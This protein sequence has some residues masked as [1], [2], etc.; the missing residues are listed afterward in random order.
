MK[1]KILLLFSCLL[2]SVGVFASVQKRDLD[3]SFTAWDDKNITYTPET[4]TFAFSA[5]WAGGSII[6]WESF[7]HE[8]Y[9]QLYVKFAS[10]PQGKIHITVTY[11]DNTNENPHKTTVKFK[12]NYCIVELNETNII[13]ISIQNDSEVASHS[14]ALEELCLRGE[15]GKADT[16]GNLLNENKDLGNWSF[17][18]RY[19]FDAADFANAQEGSR[20]KIDYTLSSEATGLG[21]YHQL[22]FYYSDNTTKF[23]SNAFALENGVLGLSDG[24]YYF[25]TLNDADIT[26]IKTGGCYISG[27][28]V[29]ITGVRLTDYYE[30][31]ET[32]QVLESSASGKEINYGQNWNQSLDIINSLAEGDKLRL[33]VSSKNSNSST[34]R[35]SWGANDGNYVATTLGS[36]FTPPC[37]VEHMLTGA[38]VTAIQSAQKLY[39]SGGTY[40]A[41]K[42]TLVKTTTPGRGE[43]STTANNVIWEGSQTI[44]WNNSGYVQIEG[45]TLTSLVEGQE[46]RFYYTGTGE[47]RRAGAQWRWG[48]SNP[49][50]TYFLD[51]TD[52]DW[53]HL[54]MGNNC[55]TYTLTSEMITNIHS[56][57]LLVTG[58]GITLTKI[59]AYTP[60]A[61][62]TISND[63]TLSGENI[64]LN[65]VSVSTSGTLTVA[66][67][68]QCYDLSINAA[69]GA[70]AQVINPNNLT[71]NGKVY[72]DLQLDP[73]GTVNTNQW[74]AFSVPFQADVTAIQGKRGGAYVAL[75]EGFAND[76][77]VLYYNGSGWA[78]QHS[79]NLT[80]GNL[81]MIGL[82]PSVNDLRFVKSSGNIQGD[83]SISLSAGW[84]ALG[85]TQV[86]HVDA[87]AEGLSYVQV[88]NSASD[89]YTTCAL[90]T[91]S[92]VV[93]SA[94]F[95]QTESAGTLTLGDA[96][97]SVLKAPRHAFSTS[98][99]RTVLL[100]IAGDNLFVEV[101]DDAEDTYIIGRDLHKL[102]N[103]TSAR[104]PLMWAEAYDDKLCAVN[105][106]ETNGVAEVPVSFYS[107]ANGTQTITLMS[108]IEDGVS[109][110]ILHDGAVVCNFDETDSQTMAL[111]KGANTGYVLRISEKAKVPTDITNISAEMSAKRYDILGREVNA[112]YRGIVIENGKKILCY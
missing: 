47:T 98:D 88:Y 14:V 112:D 56:D 111:N 93:G 7:S 54:E 10:V 74:Y 87:S 68:V 58:T 21:N 96:S 78:E 108:D 94:F 46:L 83:A 40:T 103:L 71:V 29:T 55:F 106:R 59:E 24:S 28:N 36:S 2:L 12:S 90:N 15:T 5:S 101:S 34:V 79:G 69:N 62:Q 11:S 42:W 17:D 35:F 6:P 49:S 39:I 19:T 27:Y 20:L 72:F 8:G 22:A 105:I 63:I 30:Q 37:V 23:S 16:S 52:K 100:Q 80:P 65:D 91:T 33:S 26:A 77:L 60:S 73:S 110:N 43:T 82:N 66:N 109:I 75:T 104:T 99:S 92:F 44:D 31:Y 102:G 70:S 3:V 64:V 86:R 38:E 48:T 50:V 57:K 107:P 53:L 32:E 4:K 25:L 95:A 1:A 84:N 76:Y 18:N 13:S 45:S 51:G 61:V 67:T 97:H 89:N 41:T 85:N 9:T 81:Y